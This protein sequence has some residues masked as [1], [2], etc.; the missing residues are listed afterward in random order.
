MRPD[1]A[2]L[3]DV[4]R[5]ERQQATLDRELGGR[6][7]V[8]RAELGVQALEPRVDGAFGGAQEAGDVLAAAAQPLLAQ[9]FELDG[10]EPH[11]AGQLHPP[12]CQPPVVQFRGQR[13]RVSPNLT[14]YFT[15]FSKLRLQYNYDKG[16]LFG[17]EHSVWMQLEFQLGAHTPHKF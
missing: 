14:W 8:G 7:P 1:G 17:T 15:E 4:G 3:S 6:A 11:A 5:S 16:E 9:Q 2:S 10:R 12:A 13:T